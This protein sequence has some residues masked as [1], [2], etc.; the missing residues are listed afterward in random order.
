MKDEQIAQEVVTRLQEHVHTDVDSVMRRVVWLDRDKASDIIIAAL[1]T[2]RRAGFDACKEQAARRL[3]ATAADA[4]E[5]QLP[6]FEVIAL[7]LREAAE[8]IRAM[9]PPKT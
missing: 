9:E 5:V 8:R 2:A 7:T 3:N 6:H 4:V 1:A